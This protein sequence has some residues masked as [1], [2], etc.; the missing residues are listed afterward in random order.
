MATITLRATKGSPLTNNEVDANFNNLNTEV[1]TKLDAADFTGTNILTKIKT[2]DGAL[3]GLDADTVDGIQASSFLR[4]DTGDTAT[5][6]ITFN[7]GL[8]G[9]AIF[10]TGATNFDDVTAAENV[11]SVAI[12]VYD[13]TSS[14]ANTA[15]GADGQGTVVSTGGG[16]A[17]SI[18]LGTQV[19]D[20]YVIALNST[21]ASDAATGLGAAVASWAMSGSVT[22]SSGGSPLNP[23]P[24]CSTNAFI[25]DI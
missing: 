11:A 22:V 21:V 4:S 15:K 24:V 1:G 6:K 12:K 13:I 9:Q 23:D 2:V 19:A 18:D 17:F 14:A 5:G 25:T 10:L 20:D 7:S 3:S 16:E 8:D